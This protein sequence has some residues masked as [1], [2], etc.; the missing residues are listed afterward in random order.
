[1]KKDELNKERAKEQIEYATEK[2]EK[3]SKEKEREHERQIEL[4]RLE[5]GEKRR[6]EEE[7]QTHEKDI[8]WTTLETTRLQVELNGQRWGVA[9]DDDELQ[10]HHHNDVSFDV[11]KIVR[12]IPPE[13]RKMRT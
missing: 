12:V 1:M 9:D 3:E 5:M 13:V 8:E 10:C 6:L 4:K 7:H 2:E 11:A